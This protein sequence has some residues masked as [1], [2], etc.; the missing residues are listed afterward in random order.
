MDTEHTKSVTAQANREAKIKRSREDTARSV[1]D[2]L[3]KH[4]NKMTIVPTMKIAQL[5][6]DVD[7]DT[8]VEELSAITSLE[9]SKEELD[10]K[11]LTV[12]DLIDLV[13]RKK[14]ENETETVQQMQQENEDGSLT[15]KKD[16]NLNTDLKGDPIEEKNRDKNASNEDD[17]DSNL[18]TSASKN[19]AGAGPVSED[20]KLR[21]KPSDDQV[22]D[23][24]QQEPTEENT[25]PDRQDTVVG[26]SP[27]E[28]KDK[29]NK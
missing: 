18:S 24:D 20:G 19:S 11:G 28:V 8:F 21:E 4:S 22:I 2:V 26:D 7:R 16:V 3:K 10:K 23:T 1:F 29:K 9:I 25:R 5:G 14:I 17:A 27:Q 13:D 15:M 6:E 12:D